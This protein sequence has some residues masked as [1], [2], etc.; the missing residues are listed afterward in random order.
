VDEIERMTD[1]QQVVDRLDR[2]LKKFG[3]HAWLITGLPNPGDRIDP[4]M[5]L[6]GWPAGWTELYTKLNLVQ[7]D[8]VVAHCFR[9]NSPFEWVDAPYD[10]VTNPRA[11]EVMDRA[12]DFRMN[13][14]FCVPIHTSEGFQAVVTMAGDVVD[15]EG[16]A[17]R[18][19]HLMALYSHGKA[20]EL[21]GQRKFPKPKLLTKREREIL[22]W[23]AVGK[24]AWEVSQILH[25]SEETVVSHV[26]AAA[27]KFDTPNR[28]A[29]VVAALR[30]GE[31]SL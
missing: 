30:R 19:L 11:K 24:T 25:I 27:A 3:F 14:G 23:T 7:N 18:A 5:M 28:V 20:V 10:V 31:I 21:C 22:Q 2:E 12:T 6:N 29:T 26:K 4:L 1:Q 8:P 17:K 16:Q 15:I 13:K 9:S